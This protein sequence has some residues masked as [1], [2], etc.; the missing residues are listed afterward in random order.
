MRFNE[1]RFL[2]MAKC[3]KTERYIYEKEIEAFDYALFLNNLANLYI[4][5]GDYEEV[6][7]LI[8]IQNAFIC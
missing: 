1:K 4:E 8:K 3:Y 7:K 2:F 6:N 5:A